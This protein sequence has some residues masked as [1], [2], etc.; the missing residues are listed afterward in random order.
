MPVSKRVE[1]KH[2]II[3]FALAFCWG[4]S[5][6]FIKIAVPTVP[7]FTIVAARL[8]L[9][10]LILL[11]IVKCRG[12]R[13]FDHIVQ[14]R[15]FLIMGLFANALPFA[16][17]TGAE[18]MISSS[19]A[20]IVNGSTPI[21]VAIIAH[22]LI[23]TE[24][25]HLRKVIGIVLGF[26]GLALVYLPSL[27][28]K[29]LG[30]E[31]GVLMM[32]GASISYAIGIVYG[33]KYLHKVPGLVAPTFQLICAFLLIAPFCLYFDKPWALPFPDLNGVIGIIGLGTLG[34]ALAFYLYYY[35]LQS[36]G[37][38]Y[39]SMVTL[40]FPIVGINLGVILLKERLAWN[41]YAGCG[42]ILLGLVTT[43]YKNGQKKS[44]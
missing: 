3:L 13:L 43:I 14:W 25:L 20:A 19:L 42:L 10:A 23:E 1:V 44:P 17:I 12:R 36:A 37:A 34:T 11:T 26:S 28:D 38:T 27:F 2:F 15:H 35:L 16:L 24:R 30:N 6:Y 33:R 7:T 8:L 40:L 29:V 9:G 41:S 4:P 39:L 32:V 21:F 5:F 18:I 22:F 31:I